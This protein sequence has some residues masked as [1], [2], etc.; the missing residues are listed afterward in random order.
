MVVFLSLAT[1][2]LQAPGSFLVVGFQISAQSDWTSWVPYG[3]AG[4]QQM[5]LIAM[6]LYFKYRDRNNRILEELKNGE[7]ES[8][9]CPPET[10]QTKLV[11]Q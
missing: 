8:S 10:E 3:V 7:D 11:K 4:V 5:G 2:L 6:L 9:T 1:L